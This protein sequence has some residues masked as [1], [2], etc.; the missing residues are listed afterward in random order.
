MPSGVSPAAVR[1]DL[2]RSQSRSERRCSGR[3]MYSS[4]VLRSDMSIGEPYQSSISPSRR[5]F[6]AALRRT[7]TPVPGP[8]TN[9][10]WAPGLIRGRLVEAP[11]PPEAR[12]KGSQDSTPASLLRDA[13]T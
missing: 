9:S 2:N 10:S 4:G 7:F 13:A 6:N 1:L 3:A 11:G 5:S 8:A 12:C